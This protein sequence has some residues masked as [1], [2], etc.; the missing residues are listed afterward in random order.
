MS[1]ALT[2]LSCSICHPVGV[3]NLLLLSQGIRLLPPVGMAVLGL[4]Q[5]RKRRGGSS[6]APSPL[7]PV[8]SLVRLPPKE[9]RNLLRAGLSVEGVDLRGAD[10]SRLDLA[11]V[12]LEDLD[13]TGVCLRRAVLEGADLSGAILDHADLSGANLGNADLRDT[14]LV[15]V[16]LSGA[17]LDGANL[18]GARNIRTASL[19]RCRHSRAT[20]WPAGFHP[21]R[22]GTSL[23]R[24][25]ASA[26]GLHRVSA[27]GRRTDPASRR[28]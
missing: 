11:G 4:G 14:S 18:D 13:L 19:A 15:D 24:L 27:D 17:V 1:V 6:I 10:L 7:A 8:D 12:H 5:L 3:S 2:G 16:D 25:G 21:G 23:D 28:R 22:T 26:L 20:I 9:L